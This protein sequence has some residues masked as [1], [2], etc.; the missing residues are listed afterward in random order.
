LSDKKLQ[1]RLPNNNENPRVYRSFL[2][3]KN[4][5]LDG[6]KNLGGFFKQEKKV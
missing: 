2:S 4:K 1:T 5:M 6:G 3:P